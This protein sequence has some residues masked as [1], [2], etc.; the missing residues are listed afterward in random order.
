MSSCEA[1]AQG[2]ERH[3]LLSTLRTDAHVIVALSQ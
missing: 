1:I 3:L 2:D